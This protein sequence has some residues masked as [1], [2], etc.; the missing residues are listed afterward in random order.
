MCLPKPTECTPRVNPNV[1]TGLRVIVTRPC[2][3]TNR[4]T[5]PTLVQGVASRGGCARGEWGGVSIETLSFL[6]NFAMN[7]K[8]LLKKALYYF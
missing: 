5:H 7:L 6:L 3:F 4:N 8:M 1:N 2:S